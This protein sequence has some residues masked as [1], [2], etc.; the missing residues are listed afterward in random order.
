MNLMGSF[1]LGD[2]GVLF[3]GDFDHGF[4]ED[5]RDGLVEVGADGEVREL[6]L[7]VLLSGEYVFHGARNI[8]IDPR[9]D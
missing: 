1:G 5:G 8:T 3:F 9:S 4:E 2:S 7:F 6:F